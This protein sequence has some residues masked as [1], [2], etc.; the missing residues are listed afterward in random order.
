MPFEYTPYRSPFTGAIADLI[1]RQG[2]IAAQQ[3]L[4][5]A[6][7]RTQAVSG[8]AQSLG[9]LAQYRAD[10]PKREMER[11]RIAEAR[12]QMADAQEARAGKQSLATLLSPDYVEGFQPQGPTQVDA[13]GEA[14]I[15]PKSPSLVKNIG[16]VKQL[17]PDAIQAAMGQLGHGAWF[18]ENRNAIDNLNKSMLDRHVLGQK[19]IQNAADLYKRAARQSE[20]TLDDR[21]KVQAA[22]TL[23]DALDNIVPG[24]QLEA[25]QKALGVGD[26]RM[27]DQ[28]ADQYATPDKVE[29]LK[30]GPGD[31]IMPVNQY[32]QPVADAIQ[33]AP[34]PAN[35]PSPSLKDMPN[36]YM[37]SGF[38][39]P[40]PLT[41]DDKGQMYF[42]VTPLTPEQMSSVTPYQRPERPAAPSG[43]GA[44]TTRMSDDAIEMLAV[45]L[46]AGLGNARSELTGLSEDARIRVRNAQ[47]DLNRKLERS[48]A[49]AVAIAAAAKGDAKSLESLKKQQANTSMAFDRLKPQ[50]ELVLA[51]IGKLDRKDWTLVNKA[52]DY[53]N[54]NGKQNPDVSA[55]VNAIATYTSEYAKIVEGSAGSVAAT[56]VR[57]QKKAEEM[58]PVAGS[59]AAIKKLIEQ[60]EQEAAFTVDAQAK[61]IRVSQDRIE[62]AFSAPPNTGQA[63]TPP[64]GARIL[65]LNPATG[66]LEPQ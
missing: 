46:A 38:S 54:K 4:N 23:V 17:D 65:K 50:G 21:F 24:D 58:L 59:P 32:G 63:Q 19:A 6:K 53:F 51:N 34:A 3:A 40:I 29:L 41:R 25:I 20:D 27:I 61:A 26:T 7:A 36:S 52:I 9:N 45:Q 30:I 49:A 15:L 22:Q 39:K 64:P 5:E 42:G 12:Q 44:T 28:F 37:V 2:D 57:A 66:K 8:V 31:V 55:L 47:A 14:G 10:A 35:V 62:Q 60:M 1:G 13:S 16:G 43:Q 48:P 11:M 56:T 33:G 18:L